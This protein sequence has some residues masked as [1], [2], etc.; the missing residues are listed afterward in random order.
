MNKT[1]KTSLAPR[2][3]ENTQRKTLSLFRSANQ[4]AESK[5]RKTGG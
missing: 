4:K 3:K 1:S 2:P 5:R